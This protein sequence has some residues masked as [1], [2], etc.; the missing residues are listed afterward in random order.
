MSMLAAGA[1][2]DD[3]DEIITAN[4]FIDDHDDDS[5]GNDT[6]S[7]ASSP[8]ALE[9]AVV[10]AVAASIVQHKDTK[11]TA[12]PP[13]RAH[14]LSFGA[15]TPGSR[16]SFTSVKKLSFSAAQ[17]NAL[18]GSP[19]AGGAAGRRHRSRHSSFFDVRLNLFFVVSRSFAPFVVT[20][21]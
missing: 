11:S 20:W 16:L 7:A 8:A 21:Q 4:S 13:R 14:H 6:S 5:D 9:A 10:D 2:D 18:A 1:D 3:D 12:K 15:I 17:P 19:I